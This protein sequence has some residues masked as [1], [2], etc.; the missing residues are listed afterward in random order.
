VRKVL[1]AFDAY[2]KDQLTWG[3]RHAPKLWQNP[4]GYFSAEFGFHENAADCCKVDGSAGGDHAKSASD[5]GVGLV[6][7]SVVLS[8]GLLPTGD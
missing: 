7:I 1:Q 5:L 8:R 4:V 6:G 2:L 3:H